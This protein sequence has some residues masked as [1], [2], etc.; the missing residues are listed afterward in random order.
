L[1]DNR[2]TSGYDIV[3]IVKYQ[4]LDFKGCASKLVVRK[5]F[6]K[7][8]EDECLKE[9]TP[10]VVQR[11]V[12]PTGNFAFKV[13]AICKHS[14]AKPPRVSSYIITNKKSYYE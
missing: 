1:G 4:R 14:G 3:A 5:D 12:R 10:I 11:Y 7:V 13:R 2:T 8:L 6:M 9:R